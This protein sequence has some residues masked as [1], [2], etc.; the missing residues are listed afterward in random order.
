M[1]THEERLKILT[2]VQE[3]RITAEE[4]MK[5]LEALRDEPASGISTSYG[6][7]APRWLRVRVTDLTTGK[8]KVNVRLPVGFVQAGM[9]MGA[10]F[11]IDESQVDMTAITRAISEGETGQII[12]VNNL[13][14]GEHVEVYLE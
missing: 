12:D 4:G 5:L 7:T 11:S 9:K 6:K 2:M 14:D 13:E 1:V 10:K 8:P 3:G